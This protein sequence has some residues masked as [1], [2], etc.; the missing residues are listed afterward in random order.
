MK[1]VAASI[2]ILTYVGLLTFP[3]I[4]AYIALAAAAL[5]VLLGIL[6][7]GEVFGAIDWNV[8]MMIS[9]TMG[10]VSF[11]IDSKMPARLADLIIE[12]TPNLKWCV[13][14][15]AAFA[16]L[17][18]AFIDNV[19]TVLIVAP[20]ALDIAKKLNVSPVPSII[21]I[22]V[23]SNLQGAATLVGDTTAI[24][25]GGHANLNFMDFFVFQGKPGL[26]WVVQA[27]MIASL[28]ILLLLFRRHTQAIDLKG[29]TRVKDYFPTFLL[30]GMVALLVLASF[31]P[32]KPSI[33]NGLICLGMFAVGLIRELIKKGDIRVIG[34]ALG[35]ID[36]F[37][38][39]LLAGIFVLVGGISEA[40]LIDD[41]AK[42][43]VNLGQGNL[44]VVYSLI[45]WASVLFSAFIDN[46]P[47]VATMLP[48]V[49]GIAGAMGVD[50]YL[51]YFGL[52]SG[53]TLGGNLTPVGASANITGI[54]ILRKEGYEVSTGQFMKIG[55]PFT[56]AAVTVAYVWLWFMWS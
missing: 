22:S 2:F 17:I 27:G 19:A 24:M 8:L 30:V 45:V 18:S 10:I 55:V 9:G 15:L 34:Q 11:F 42:L 13:I 38:L 56:L 16:G 29:E 53:S 46:I 41:L 3:K 6:P 23:S 40:G 48:V 36:Y 12:R 47:Y 50:P 39:L 37:T 26:F 20:I 7:A 51:L 43:F 1:Y 35:A 21:A 44:F 14:A 25:L 32:N 54:G 5:F 49:S 52:L 28:V 4:R 31:I 33:T